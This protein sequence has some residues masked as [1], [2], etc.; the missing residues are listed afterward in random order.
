MNT[1]FTPIVGVIVSGNKKRMDVFEEPFCEINDVNF[2]DGNKS[3]SSYNVDAG[4]RVYYGFKLAGYKNG[5]NLYRFTIGR[6]TELTSPQDR[7]ESTGLK[8]KNSNIVTSLDVF[9]SN[10]W[11]FIANGN[12]SSQSKRWEKIETGL[13]FSNE[14]VC[15]DLM[16]FKG[17]QYLYNPF[18]PRLKDV[19]EERKT[20][21][22]KGIMF[23][24]G[25]YATRRV[26]LKSGVVLGNDDDIFAIERRS[27]KGNCRLIRHSVGIEYKNECA[28]VDF[29]IE[30]KNYR[31]G[32]LKPETIF[33]LA[34]HLKNL[35]I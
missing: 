25:W 17:K 15:F 16:L 23:D 2:L 21:K 29:A 28:T 6:S 24:V 12:Y 10:E 9:L 13:N 14:K 18:D 22:Y 34:V 5:D 32:D 33:R 27:S 3:I 7:L 11:T 31:G 20:Q 26:K 19:S 35:G 30:R 4:D 8:Y 1:I